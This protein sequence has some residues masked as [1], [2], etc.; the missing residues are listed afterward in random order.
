MRSFKIYFTSDLHGY[1]YPTSY[2]DRIDKPLGLL[3]CF[4]K[5]QE[6]LQADKEQVGE[7]V[8]YIDNGDILQGSA[9]AYYCKQVL[10]D[11]RPISDIMNVCGFQ[12]YTLGNHDFNYGQDYVR[13]Y[14]DNHH[15][16]CLCQNVTDMDG[17]SL[18]PYTIHTLPNGLKI[19]LVGI[20]TDYVNIWEKKENLEG[21]R[22]IDP[23]VEAQKAL[24]E[25]QG[26]TDLNVCIYHGGFESDILT[27]EQLLETTENVGYKICKELNYDILLTGHQHMHVDGTNLHGT[28]VVQPQEYGKECFCI[29]VE[30]KQQHFSISS[31][32]F[33]ADG[34]VYQK[35]YDAFKPIEEKIQAWLDE[36]AGSLPE[37]LLPETKLQMALHGSKIADFL[38][39]VQLHFSKAQLSAVGLAN[40]IAGFRKKVTNR[41]IIATYPYPNTLVVLEITGKQLRQAMERSAEYFQISNTG[42]VEIA[43]SFLIP[44]V[45][46]Y[47]YDYY[48]GVTYEIDPYQ[49]IGNRIRNLSYQNKKVEDTDV[50]SICLNNYRATGAG[51]YSVY[52]E[53][54]ILKEINVEM[55]ELI[56]DYFQRK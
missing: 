44:K 5:F 40:E 32:N 43:D 25:L 29:N 47:N 53:C 49:K 38:N 19:G 52:K 34:K 50:F 6:N 46:H 39:E 51:E 12:Y 41:D 27:G 23:F 35:I 21:I 36:P 15:G 42:E 7:N 22:V 13:Q 16:R 14:I 56:I 8:L 11:N 26:K 55:V 28:Y 45:E 2:G 20:V 54:K 9:F 31:E 3:K 17:D 10:H 37:D 4:A 24:N 48:A 33:Q 1:F 30:E 18:Y